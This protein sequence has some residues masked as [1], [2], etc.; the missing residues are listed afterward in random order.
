MDE[1]NTRALK[2]SCLAIIGLI[3][4]LILGYCF[5]IILASFLII[6]GLFMVGFG[7]YF[8]YIIFDE[9]FYDE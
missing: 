9:I 6:V 2:Y 3:I 4:Y 5:P 7:V 8:T 1:I